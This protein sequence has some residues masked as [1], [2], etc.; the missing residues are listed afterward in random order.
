[1]GVTDLLFTCADCR[2]T[3][4]GP[5]E[6]GGPDGCEVSA[7]ARITGRRREASLKG[8]ICPHCL[9]AWVKALKSEHYEACLAAAKG[10]ETKTNARAVVFTPHL[11]GPAM[12]GQGIWICSSGHFQV[13]PAEAK[14]IMPERNAWKTR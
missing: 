1:M 11:R 2:Q 9:D 3:Y 5:I 12:T 4:K 8:P 7:L 14:T 6:H 13:I 10:W